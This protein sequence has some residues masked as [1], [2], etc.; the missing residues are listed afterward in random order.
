M[1]LKPIDDA[2]SWVLA[3]PE[4][5]FKA[6]KA[7]DLELAQ[8]VWMDATLWGCR[9]VIVHHDGAV[10]AIAG[11]ANWLHEKPLSAPDLFVRVVPL[12]AAGPNSMRSEILLN[13]FC[14]EVVALVGATVVFEK[15]ATT[16]RPVLDD[17]LRRWT[18]LEAGIAFRL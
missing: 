6:G 14:T 17:L 5:Y 8:S 13:A 18:G 16:V 10:W 1:T 15:S 2:V 3:H 11:S 9:D 4:R 12:T 7:D